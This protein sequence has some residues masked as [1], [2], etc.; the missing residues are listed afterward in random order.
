MSGKLL[1]LIVHK[2]FTLTYEW[3]V[4]KKQTKGKFVVRIAHL[5]VENEQ[6]NFINY[7]LF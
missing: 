4:E 3:K 1:K 7:E 5:L 2:S 6:F